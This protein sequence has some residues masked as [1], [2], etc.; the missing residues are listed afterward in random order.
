MSH[1]QKEQVFR[2]LVF[3][4]DCCRERADDANIS[5]PGWDKSARQNGQVLTLRGY[6]TIFGELAFEPQAQ[7]QDPDLLRG[8]FT[9]ALLEGLR[10][11]KAV[12]P[13]TRVIDSVSLTDFVT[14]R[15]RVLT[16]SFPKPQTPAI[17]PD[18]AS[19]RIVFKQNIPTEVVDKVIQHRVQLT[20]PAGF[21]GRVQLLNGTRT[22]VATSDVGDPV[23]KLK[24]DKG[25]YRVQLPDGTSPFKTSG[26]FE[27]FGEDAHVDL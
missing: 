16:A 7:Q 12:N 9:Q 6:A 25:I 19:P 5:G 1:F 23:W 21:Q 18:P 22:V 15:V 4:A 10:E 27:V 24:L 3:F 26:Y 20:F 17:T 11:H 2:E 14:E 13:A 8:Y